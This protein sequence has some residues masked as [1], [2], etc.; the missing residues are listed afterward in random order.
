MGVMRLF[1]LLVVLGLAYG[2]EKRGLGDAVFSNWVKTELYFGLSYINS[3]NNETEYISM[4]EFEEFVANVC[5]PLFPS[6][7]TLIPAQGQWQSLVTGIIGKEPSV[8][9][10]V[11]HE[12]SESEN[13]A[14]QQIVT[15]YMEQF[16]QEAVLYANIQAEACITAYECLSGENSFPTATISQIAL[17]LSC[18]T[19]VM[20]FCFMLLVSY[21]LRKMEFAHRDAFSK[22]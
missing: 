16:S 22:F 17:A 13:D 21:K 14:I 11:Y 1:V 10:I 7:L 4:D 18:V 12:D 15:E 20:L 8:L 6:G 5:T 3:T 2:H 19:F 9:M